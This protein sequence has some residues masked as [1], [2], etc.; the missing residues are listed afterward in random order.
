MYLFAGYG[1]VNLWKQND[2]KALQT[3]NSKIFVF[4]FCNLLNSANDLIP[5][6][7]KSYVKIMLSVS[8][9]ISIFHWSKL[10]LKY[11]NLFMERFVGNFSKKKQLQQYYLTSYNLT[12]TFILYLDY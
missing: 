7:K 2:S 6:L 8:I 1:L 10:N 9:R 11:G 5:S 3:E 12:A 4:F